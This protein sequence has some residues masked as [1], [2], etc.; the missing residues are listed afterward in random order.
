MVVAHQLWPCTHPDCRASCHDNVSLHCKKTTPTRHTGKQF[1]CSLHFLFDG[2][3]V[4]QHQHQRRVAVGKYKKRKMCALILLRSYSGD[5]VLT[6]KGT[7]KSCFPHQQRRAFMHL[8]SLFAFQRVKQ[9]VGKDFFSS[10]CITSYRLL[11]K[12]FAMLL[13]VVHRQTRWA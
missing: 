6:T 4:P 12:M 10:L 11:H 5:V 13:M 1:A 8:K 7:S 9:C 3:Q 2:N